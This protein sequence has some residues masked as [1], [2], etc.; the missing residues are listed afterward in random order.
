MI[1]NAV[2]CLEDYKIHSKMKLLEMAYAGVNLH[3]HEDNVCGYCWQSECDCNFDIETDP[4]LNLT[5]NDDNYLNFIS[6]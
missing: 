2:T 5:E 6:K 1:E 4:F 3:Y